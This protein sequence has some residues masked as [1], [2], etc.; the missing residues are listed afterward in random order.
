MLQVALSIRQPWAWSII[1]AGKDIE[2]RSWNTNYRGRFYIHAA[3]GL[4]RAE[5]DDF[6]DFTGDRFRFSLPGHLHCPP[7]DELR[8]GGIIGE[9]E[10]VDCV[11]EHISPWFTGKYGFLLR[12]PKPLPFRPLS[13]ELGFCIVEPEAQ[14]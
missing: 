7:A 14:T 11:R 12:N 6:L 4:T 8:R 9:A 13:G 2:N 1:H 10:L 5:Y 3:K